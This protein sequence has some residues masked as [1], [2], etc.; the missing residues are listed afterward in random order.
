MA[1]RLPLNAIQVSVAPLARSNVKPRME[2]FLL[3]LGP[4][5]RTHANQGIAR[6]PGFDLASAITG[7]LRA[8]GRDC[9]IA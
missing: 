1:A 8:P 3:P 6:A 5:A 7:L 4:E 2:R 9:R